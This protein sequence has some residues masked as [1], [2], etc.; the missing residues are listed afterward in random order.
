MEPDALKVL[1]YATWRDRL[2]G[3]DEPD[4]PEVALQVPGGTVET[5]EDIAAAALREF[6]EET[7]IL[8]ETPLARSSFM[9]IA[10]PRTEP[11]FVTGGTTSTFPSK[12]SN[13]PAGCIAK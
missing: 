12:V 8:P 4:F 3:F 2:L 10:F 11:N 5:G 9:T 13:P 6:S 1:I 7:G